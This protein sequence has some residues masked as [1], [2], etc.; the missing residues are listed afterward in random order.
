MDKRQFSRRV[1]G[2]P[3]P[4]SS[5]GLLW[6]NIQKKIEKEKKIQ[7]KLQD[8]DLFQLSY[9]FVVGFSC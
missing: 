8:F 6:C 9:V 5:D 7:F 2:D 1:R 3:N 4:G